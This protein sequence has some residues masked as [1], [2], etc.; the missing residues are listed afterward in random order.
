MARRV[1]LGRAR[2]LVP[3]APVHTHA[4]P[5][6]EDVPFVTSHPIAPRALLIRILPAIG[7]MALI[8]ILSAQSTLPP[9]P[10]L[11]AEARAIVG[12]FTVYG[13]LAGL[14]WWALGLTGLAPGRR[15]LI[16]FLGAVTYGLTDEL[17]QAFVPGRDASFFDIAVD[18]IGATTGLA[19]LRWFLRRGQR[20]N[21]RVLA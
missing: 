18:A 3:R 20:S 6:Q 1:S 7:W 10:G 4:S 12:H 16:A 2:G 15:M 8:F 21:V 11:T 17:H 9:A 13:V 19:I 14:Y 5:V